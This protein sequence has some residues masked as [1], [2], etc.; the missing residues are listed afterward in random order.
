[1]LS[2]LRAKAIKNNLVDS[3]GISPERIAAKGEG[4]TQPVAD[5]QT[6]QGRK[7]NRR[8]EIIL[9]PE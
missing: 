1:V 8:V 6:G 2:Q 4:D 7:L 9:Q 5:N 3:F